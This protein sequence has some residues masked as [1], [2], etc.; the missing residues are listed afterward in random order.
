VIGTTLGPYRIDSELGAGGMGSVFLATCEED[1]Q[2]ARRGAR[3]AIKVVHPHLLSTPG[4]FKR[5]LREADLGKAVRHENVV[6]TLDVDAT[7]LDG[8]QANYLVM[9]YVEGRTLREML[10]D[11]RTV[12]EALLREL[13]SQV[14][15]GLAAIHEQGIVHRDLKPENVLV[16]KDHQVRI[17]DLGV[18][19]LQ[20]ATV[21]ITKEG[22]FAGSLLYAAPE[23][24]RHEGVGPA[25]D[26]YSLGVMLYELATGSNPFERDSAAQVIA[27]HLSLVPR[28]MRDVNSDVSAFL[29]EIAGTL[30]AKQPSGRFPSATELR[31]V[32]VDGESSAWWKARET[33][34]RER[35]HRLPP[36]QVRRE[37]ELHGREAELALLADAWKRAQEG[38]GS[39]VFMEGEA[40]IGKTRLVDAFMRSL[41]TGD[42][43]VLYGS[44]P[45][46][47]GVGGLSDAIT[48]K[49]GRAQL[50]DALKPYLTV[51]PSLVPAFAAMLQHEAPPTGSEPLTG[52]AIHA[53]FCHLAKSLATEKPTLWV[54]DELHFSPEDSRKVVLALARAVQSLRILLVV[55]ARPGLSEEE[56][57]H[58][59]RLDNFRR[60]PVGRL[61][62]RQVI[63]CLRDAFRSDVL[64]ER[65]GGKIAFKS[66]GVPFFVFEMI[67]GLKE[68]QFIKQQADGTYVETQIVSDIEVPSAVRDLIEG[69]LRDLTKEE[70]AILDVGA[71][72]GFEFDPDL[73]ARVLE[74]KR[75][76]VLQT[77][78]DLERRSGVVRAA[79]RNYRFDHHQIQEILHRGLSDSLREEYHAMLAEAFTVREKLADKAPK[80]VPG[81]AAIFL[82]THGLGGSRPEDALPILTRALDHLEGAYRNATAIEL[83]DRALAIEGLVAGAPRAELLLRKAGWLGW[84]GHV[85]EQRTALDEAQ[86]L[87]ETSGDALLR[88]KAKSGLASHVERVDTEQARQL[89]AEALALALTGGDRS[90]QAEMRRGLAGALNL[91]GRHAEA[92]DEQREALVVA[93]EAGDRTAEA[94]A[95]R[96]LAQFAWHMGRLDEAESFAEEALAIARSMS[97]HPV[98]AA[99]SAVLAVVRA[100]QGRMAEAVPLFRRILEV[101]RASGNRQ[102]EAIALSNLSEALSRVGDFRGSAAAI[103]ECASVARMLALRRAE[104]AVH[105]RLAALAYGDGRIVD[106]A[107]H[108]VRAEALTR[109]LRSPAYLAEVLIDYGSFEASRGRT[110]DARRLLDEADVLVRDVD[111]PPLKTRIAAHRAALP[112]G[113]VAAARATFAENEP[114]IGPFERVDIRFALWRAAH[115]AADLAAAWKDL[116]FLRDHAPEEN[117]ETILTNVPL[118][119]EIAAAAKEA[120]L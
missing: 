95:L 33:V 47:G 59:S 38:H 110:D 92:S 34:V 23:Q 72:M 87:A 111:D 53:V 25:T 8:K 86:G 30:L 24:F 20:E 84:I 67:R 104:R 41:G 18:A 26:L 117:K 119:R 75:I 78:A 55:T 63:E 22:Q 52:D 13:A 54:V 96:F 44:Y 28:P 43:H 56:L 89:Y 48:E 66:D 109:E 29:A 51:T 98:E 17:M 19:R 79:G 2:G 94:S 99:A 14:A 73:V 61:S 15:A 97:V 83:A 120:G 3:V 45:P 50:A 36:V 9:E 64:A 37:T 65:L 106:A 31:R 116:Q 5:F 1:T 68:G 27:A 81:E 60:V 82:A 10:R 76:L 42:F 103:T 102:S 77:L 7:L 6:R 39:T 62:P 80:D 12:P 58:F 16:T 69:R 71:V 21:A 112:G 90:V 91:L 70:R 93:R 118:H 114:R 57:A 108:Y 105:Q 46:S 115:D 113:D 32:L 11:L 88:A 74:T 49:F 107:D 40:G 4:F 101:T 35:E 100:L 85:E